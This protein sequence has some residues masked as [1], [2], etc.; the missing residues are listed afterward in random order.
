MASPNV[1]IENENN[2]ALA[3]YVKKIGLAMNI[4]IVSICE[5][6]HCKNND[7]IGKIVLDGFIKHS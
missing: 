6:S 1:L 3:Y 4:I 7:N 2:V 5:K